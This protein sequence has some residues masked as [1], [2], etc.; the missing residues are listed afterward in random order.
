[1]NDQFTH[2][3]L[4]CAVQAL[5]AAQRFLEQTGDTLLAK[6]VDLLAEKVKLKLVR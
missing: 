5:E 3:T 4:W 1:M 6:E 2:D